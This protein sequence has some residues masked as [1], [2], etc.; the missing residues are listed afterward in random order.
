MGA[1]ALLALPVGFWGGGYT[2]TAVA[3]GH[4]SGLLLAGLRTLPTLAVLP[5][6]LL[7]G[8]R[9]PR[10]ADIRGAICSGLLVVTVFFVGISEGTKH[11]GA[12]NAAV[13]ISAAPLWVALLARVFLRERIPRTAV[14]GLGLGFAGIVVMVS[15]QLG[16][17]HGAGDLALGIGLALAA[18]IAWAAG[19]MIVRR[20]AVRNPKLDFVGLT[21]A[22]YIAGSPILIVVALAF[23]GIGRTDWGSIDLWGATLWLALGS[24][25][26][27][28]V[29]FFMSLRWL[30]AA[31]TSSSQFLVPVVAVV[32]EFVRGHA[33]GA[34]VL[35]GMALAILGVALVVA[36]ETVRSALIRRL[37]PA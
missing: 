8:A 15:R 25:A 27:A 21:A 34:L 26:I 13:L 2:A 24:S 23:G 5:L 37:R 9:L 16:G 22:Q 32:V 36:G 18:G 30:N 35:V 1:W 33:P 29:A 4:T 6:A 28:T 3:T 17:R 10:G 7:F 20:M 14:A 19:T 31:Q 11:A 12:A